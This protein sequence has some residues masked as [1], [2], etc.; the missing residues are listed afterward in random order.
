MNIPEELKSLIIRY[1]EEEPNKIALKLKN[2]GEA[3][4][5]FVLNQISGFRI[6][7]KKVPS[8]AGIEDIIYPAHL[9]LEQCSS[10][11]TAVYKR[12]VAEK[13]TGKRREKFADLTGGLGVDCH[14]LSSLYDSSIYVERNPEL[15]NI[16]SHNFSILEDRLKV[17]NGDSEEFLSTNDNFD[18]VFIDPARRDEK[19]SR[20]VYI[21]DCSPDVSKMEED[22]VKKSRFVM[23]KLSPMLDISRMIEELRHILEI[24]IVTVDNECKEILAVLSENADS[25]NAEIVCVELNDRFSVNCCRFNIGDEGKSAASIASKPGKY[26]YEP[27]AALMKSGAFKLICSKYLVEKFHPNSH[28]YTSDILVDFPG[29]RFET[30]G[31]C[32]FGKSELAAFLKDTEKANISIRNFPS[33]VDSLRKRLKIKDG[34]DIYIFATTLNDGR[35]VLVKGVKV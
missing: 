4:K 14:F 18:L 17:I 28:L 7:K 5:Q 11:L 1:K 6:A 29:R 13:I 8:W 16:A 34:G 15:C 22:L 31:Y 32:G 33:T 10:E 2:I 24:H 23:I 3:D 26:I 35:K 30:R 21:K 12:N 20:T 9:S 19:G 25:A 27:S